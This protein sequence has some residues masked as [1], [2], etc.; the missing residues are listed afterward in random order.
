M[1]GTAGSGGA[2]ASAAPSPGVDLGGA[3]IS[4]DLRGGHGRL[5]HRLLIF[6]GVG[7][8]AIIGLGAL[9]AVVGAPPSARLCRPYQ[10]CGAPPTMAR[11]LVN[12]TVWRSS[13]YGFRLEYPG[14]DAT[15]SQQDAGSVTLG[16]D[17]GDG[18]KGA[19]LIQGSP[20]P[21]SQA[22]A[23]QV[24]NLTGA[25]QV[26]ADTAPADQLLG[27]GVGYRTGV[28][29]VH[30]GYFS[31]PQGVGQPINLASEAASNG[32]VTVSVTVGGPSGKTGPRSFLYEL[33]DLI[34]NS[35]RWSG[36]G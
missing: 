33:A 32:R 27:S 31:A 7:F 8:A 17:L 20:A 16:A 36:G 4:H 24:S 11:P 3:H 2:G 23:D 6:F 13:Q 1:N 21:P 9:G 30:V 22:I 19:I 35:V 10:P 5:R 25:T 12:E 18:D 34:I 28:G 26:S 15:I 14:N 29:S